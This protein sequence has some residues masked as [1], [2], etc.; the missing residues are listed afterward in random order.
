M[1]AIFMQIGSYLIEKMN[2]RIQMAI[3]GTC[4]VVPLFLCSLITN[5]YL[6][7]FFYAVVVGLGFGLLY[8]VSLRNAWQFFPSKKGMLSGMIM[9][10]YSFGAILWVL[11][12]K[13]IANPDNIKPTE[14]VQVEEK[15]EK[16]YSA[17]SEV[18]KNVPFMLQ[19]LA[20]IYGI[21]LVFATLLINKRV[22]T[23][24]NS[25]RKVDYGFSFF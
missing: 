1:S 18:V 23:D 9:S 5:F 14:I 6:F 20:L 25:D 21:M 4:I 10:C 12:T 17:D 8:M 7:V 15:I 11:L 13:A 19:M 3:G 24:S 2:P 16:F 22:F